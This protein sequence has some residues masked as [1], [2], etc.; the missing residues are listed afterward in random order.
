MEIRGEPP[1]PLVSLVEPVEEAVEGLVKVLQLV[2]VR[3]RTGDS[4]PACR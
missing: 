3:N 1:L 2:A 4:C